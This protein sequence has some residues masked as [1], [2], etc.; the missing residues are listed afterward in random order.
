MTICPRSSRQ[1]LHALPALC[2]ALVLATS[3]I[4]A[5]QAPSLDQPRDPSAVQLLVSAAVP[6]G[7]EATGL[8][9]Q[10]LV[11]GAGKSL[12]LE[13]DS[14]VSRVSMANPSV[15]DT[16]V[17]SPEQLLI[18]GL[19]PGSTSLVMW[20]ETGAS[21]YYD[22]TVQI[23][24]EDLGAHLKAFFP[25]EN[26]QVAKTKGTLVLNGTVS[27]PEIGD[28][29]L[30][31]A[32][33]YSGSVINNMTYPDTGRQQIA[34]KILFAEVDRE[35]MTDLSASF[36]RIDPNNPRGGNEGLISPGIPSASGNF[37]NTP[38]GP[39]FTFND[40]INLYAFNLGHSISG[41]INA[42]K[43]KGQLQILAEPTLIAADGEDASFLAGGEFP[44]PVAQAGA[45][46]TSVTIIYKKF[47][48]S[49]D[50]KPEIRNKDTIVLRVQPEVSALDFANAVTLSGFR[51]PAL[52]VRRADTEIELRNGQSFAIAGLYSADLQ[53]SKKKIPLLG[54]IPL[55]GYLF[56]S[57]NLNKRKTELVVIAT[58]TIV[59]PNDPGV[60]PA[61]P[62]FDLDME[63][64]KEE[65][66]KGKK[67]QEVARLELKT[68][69][70]IEEFLK[71]YEPATLIDP[72]TLGLGPRA[73][74]AP[75]GDGQTPGDAT[76]TSAG[77]TAADPAAKPQI[78]GFSDGPA[79]AEEPIPAP[80]AA[81]D[82]ESPAPQDP[83]A[84][85]GGAYAP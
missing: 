43:T 18:N 75:N 39:D 68:E 26:I 81:D 15:A 67:E 61:L 79:V 31:I 71:G 24:T 38:Q 6:A 50:F 74:K 58:P 32:G 1:S 30:K 60:Q 16:L 84:A 17:I 52:R 29:A 46:F 12:I 34:L 23:E 42:L 37:I 20:F 44:I 36:T 9:P 85:T 53:E 2:L 56:R 19:V 47:G 73:E 55:L 63:I 5:S 66:K 21:R 72:G 22:L 10:E 41:F 51:V 59:F 69:A 76:P 28:R 78:A 7:A 27:N 80:K 33:E 3:P 14:K 8:R 11:V 4:S 82:K 57:K 77:T 45:G 13:L 25:D 65:G 48:I 70:Q 62:E 54:D 35:A 49:L 83:P 64:P 40:A